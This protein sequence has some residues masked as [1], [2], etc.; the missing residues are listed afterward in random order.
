[1]KNVVLTAILFLNSLYA[2]AGN[3]NDT[4]YKVYVG[5]INHF[6]KYI[7]WPE[8]KRNGI[9]LI[10]ILGNSPIKEELVNYFNDKYLF[11]QKI[12]VKQLTSE[13]DAAECHIVFVADNSIHLLQ[14]VNNMAK[15]YNFLIITDYDGAI[16]K[17]ADFNFKEVLGSIKF[18]LNLKNVTSH[19]LKVSNK[20]KELAILVIN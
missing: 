13:K 6:T 1:M 4:R 8:Q 7:Q 18:E 16:N 19:G 17:G 20:L 11:N 5:F 12:Q 9:F 15:Y 3:I 2:I 14:K 10:G